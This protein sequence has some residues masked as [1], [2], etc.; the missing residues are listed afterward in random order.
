MTAG[1]QVPLIPLF[2]VD[3]SI[4]GAAFTHNG[5]TA[6]NTGIIAALTV[7]VKLVAVAHWPAAGVNV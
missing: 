5:P 6:L 7:T 4:G 1:F 3:G 2:E